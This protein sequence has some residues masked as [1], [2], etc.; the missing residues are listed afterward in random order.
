MTIKKWLQDNCLK[1]KMEIQ[2]E[3]KSQGIGY[4][5]VAQRIRECVGKDALVSKE[6]LISEFEG[7]LK[8]GKYPPHRPDGFVN[9]HG[10][11][12]IHS[13]SEEELRDFAEGLEV[14][15][16]TI[17]EISKSYPGFAVELHEQKRDYGRALEVA[18][19]LG[20]KRFDEVL[21]G[22]IKETQKHGKSHPEDYS[23]HMEPETTAHGRATWLAHRYG[24]DKQYRFASLRE[25]VANK[26]KERY[27]EAGEALGR[28]GLKNRANERYEMAEKNDPRAA[29]K[30]GKFRKAANLYSKKQDHLNFFRVAMEQGYDEAV[31]SR[32]ANLGIDKIRN[33]NSHAW[34]GHK[35]NLPKQEIG[36]LVDIAEKYAAENQRRKN[37]IKTKNYS[38]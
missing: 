16:D 35:Y 18:K 25:A 14:W 12:I 21:V 19:K 32:V 11:N 26:R 10:D 29:E 37:H 28:I 6:Y 17:D 23:V 7:F 22:G 9:V 15:V 3:N 20:K 27:F 31:I 4:N 34:L 30:L 2:N 38:K 8:H 13:L 1:N 24:T 5:A 36:K 33:M